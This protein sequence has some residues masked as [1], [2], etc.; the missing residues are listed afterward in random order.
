MAA[1]SDTAETVA[2]ETEKKDGDDEKRKRSQ[3]WFLN[4]G[5]FT[6]SAAE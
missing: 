2:E 5:D 1:S 4:R 3:N 6:V